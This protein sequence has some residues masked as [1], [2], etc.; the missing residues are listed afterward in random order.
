LIDAAKAILP[1]APR[2]I[3]G[4]VIYTGDHILAKLSLKQK[5]LTKSIYHPTNERNP[6]HL[7]AIKQRRNKVFTRLRDRRKKLE[8]AHWD[9][10]ARGL[11]SERTKLTTSV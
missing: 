5:V 10:I 4:K 8:V 7:L 1:I 6:A 3:N 9:R 2:K 11:A